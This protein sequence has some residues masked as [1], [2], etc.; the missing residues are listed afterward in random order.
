MRWNPI[1]THFRLRSKFSSTVAAAC[2]VTCRIHR[3]T[4]WESEVTFLALIMRQCR[5]GNITTMMPRY[6][7]NP[8]AENPPTGPTKMLLKNLEVRSISS[9][10]MFNAAW[11]LN[12]HSYGFGCGLNSGPVA[13]RASDRSIVN[14]PFAFR[15]AHG[16]PVAPTRLLGSP[17]SSRQLAPCTRLRHGG[18][19]GTAIL[20]PAAISPAPR[21]S[22]RVISLKPG[23]ST[24]QTVRTSAA[25]LPPHHIHY[26][27]SL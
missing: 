12:H 3:V 10:A 4:S 16:D 21:N 15:I 2:T 14:S 18:I 17:H 1:G 22:T 27:A 19:R 8:V 7:E 11:I 26:P 6:C 9:P 5:I 25:P 23:D 24:L 13:I 20:V